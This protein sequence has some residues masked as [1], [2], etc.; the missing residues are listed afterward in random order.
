VIDTETTGLE[1]SDQVIELAVVDLQGNAL[2]DTRIRTL[3]PIGDGAR[4]VHGISTQDLADAPTFAE[5]WPRLAELWQGKTV[6]VF[7]AEFDERLLKQTRYAH[8]I[9]A[10]KEERPASWLCLMY[11]A[12]DYLEWEYRPSLRDACWQLGVAPGNHSAL[13]DARAA[14]GVLLAM[15]EG[16]PKKDEE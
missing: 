14:L 9:K 13:A 6:A 4:A 5:V 3:V 15:A 11:T 8:D 16:K 10:A 2:L 12:Q 1:W 7:N